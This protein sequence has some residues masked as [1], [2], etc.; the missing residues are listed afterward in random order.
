MQLSVNICIIREMGWIQ[1]LILKN[2]IRWI[3][4]LNKI[5]KRICIVWLVQGQLMHVVSKITKW[6]REISRNDIYTYV[7]IV[8]RL[9]QE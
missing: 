6:M 4:L 3:L 2:V 5:D 1:S 9:L 8:A 7:R